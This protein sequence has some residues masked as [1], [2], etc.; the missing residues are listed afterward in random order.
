[1]CLYDDCLYSLHP[2]IFI[3]FD[4]YINF[5]HLSYLKEIKIMKKI[6]YTLQEIV[7]STTVEITYE[8]PLISYIIYEDRIR[9]IVS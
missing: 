7:E 6:K 3:A 1:L 2:Q 9:A 4:F 5:D 8:G